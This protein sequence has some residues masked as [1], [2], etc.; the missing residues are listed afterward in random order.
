[1]KVPR[2]L[3]YPGSK[4]SMADWIIEHIPEHTTYLEPCFGSGAVFFNKESSALETIND[5]Y[6]DVENLFKVIRD[7]P[8]DFSK[9]G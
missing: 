9:Q 3:H 7:H 6:G 8:Q 2:I 1:M 5:H 4:C